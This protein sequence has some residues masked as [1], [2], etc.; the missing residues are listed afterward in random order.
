MKPNPLIVLFISIL[1]VS[2]AAILIVLCSAPPLSISFYRLLFTTI[3][4][5]PALILYPRYRQ[6]I[7]NLSRKSLLIMLLIGVILAVHFSLWI[8][9]LKLTSVASSVILVTAHPVLV[10]PISHFF[11]KEHLSKKNI[12]GISISLIGVVILV[13]ANYGFTGSGIDPFTGNILAFLG[14]IA[15]G[16]YILGGRIMRKQIS[17]ITYAITV[18]SIATIVLFV[19]VLINGSPLLGLSQRDL[20]LIFLMAL[21]A[22]IFGHTFYNWSLAHL[23]AS[24]ASVALLG[25]PIGSSLLAYIIPW[26][27]Q[28]PT[29]YTLLGGGIILS[30]IYLTARQKKTIPYLEKLNV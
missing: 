6:E 22:G 25:E 27:N 23:R 20:F 15:A 17:T 16:L 9:S 30:G 14:G 11:L 24:F 3:L 26:I 12:I 5:T 21:I 4:L 29:P 18:Y 7:K 10:G 1:S 19:F 2:F 8:S 28:I 13:Y